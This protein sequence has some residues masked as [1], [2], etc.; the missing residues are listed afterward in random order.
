M[1]C[2]PQKRGFQLSTQ[3]HM[4]W[5][6][7]KFHFKP[8]RRHFKGWDNKLGLFSPFLALKW[9][10]RGVSEDSVR[11]WAVLW[12]NFFRQNR[13]KSINEKKIAQYHKSGVSPGKMTCFIGN[14]TKNNAYRHNLSINHLN[15]TSIQHSKV[16]Y[17]KLIFSAFLGNFFRTP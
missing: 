17:L 13:S 5:F 4:L 12:G 16:A 14:S 8:P 10:L 11:L 2:K 1:I 7:K 15:L 3:K 6:R 9:R